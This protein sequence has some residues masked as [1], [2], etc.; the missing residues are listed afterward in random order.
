MIETTP[1]FGGFLVNIIITKSGSSKFNFD[2]SLGKYNHG[3]TSLK[4]V[5][6]PL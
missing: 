2:I 5:K 3:E 1:S 4:T 6:V